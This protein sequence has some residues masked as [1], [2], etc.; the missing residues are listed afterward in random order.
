MAVIGGA[1]SA[2]DAALETYRKGA[3]V[4]LIVRGETIKN[5]IKYWVKPDIENRI[6]NKEIK[7]LF[8]SQVKEIREKEII[9]ETPKGIMS[10]ANDYV[11]AM[12]GYGPNYCLLRKLG[13]Q[14][15]D[16]PY[17]KP[18]FNAK[19]MESNVKGIYLA[20]VV[21]GGKKSNEWFIEIL[22]I[23]GKKSLKTF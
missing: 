19:T 23:M 1:N 8:S 22:W 18:I 10:L 21:C 2:V 7:A 16:S 11:L 5:T 6:K 4:T 20:G 12:T 9:V 3:Q 13:I 15:D 14:F 17:K